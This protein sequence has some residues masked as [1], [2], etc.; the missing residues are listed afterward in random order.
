[1]LSV[2]SPSRTSVAASQRELE[3][4]GKAAEVKETRDTFRCGCQR[5]SLLRK[6]RWLLADSAC[7]MAKLESR[8]MAKPKGKKRTLVEDAG[9]QQRAPATATTAV[10]RAKSWGP[11]ATHPDPPSTTTTTSAA[12]AT[13]TATA[14]VTEAIL[15][16]V[17]QSGVLVSWSEV[18]ELQRTSLALCEVCRR[19]IPVRVRV[20]AETPRAVWAARRKYN[21][22]G[23]TNNKGSRARRGGRRVGRNDR[24]GDG[25]HQAD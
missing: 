15:P 2:A 9:I 13:R 17:V 1:G 8:S 25:G 24:G 20:G 3:N 16:L 6:R 5:P 4:R 11:T 14:I 21:E 7:I 19:C 22:D 12:P 10:G 23:S 18:A